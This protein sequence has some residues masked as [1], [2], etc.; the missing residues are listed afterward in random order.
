LRDVIAPAG[1]ADSEALLALPEMAQLAGARVLIL[2]G[3]G[4]RELLGETLAARGAQVEVAEV[5]RRVRPAAL[6]PEGR[7]DAVC[8]SSGEALTNLAALLGSERLRR[9]PV[10]VSH[11][12]VVAQA[13]NLGLQRPVL[14]GP[15]DADMLASLVAYFDAA[16]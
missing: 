16:K 10:F 15:G 11:P 8:V 14:A 6:P 1:Q 4:G 5:Y 2:R 13:A 3:A 9:T 12:R 7:I